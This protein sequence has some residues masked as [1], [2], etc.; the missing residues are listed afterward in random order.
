MCTL[1]LVLS[2][3]TFLIVVNHLFVA[4]RKAEIIRV[5]EC[6]LDAINSGDFETYTY[7]SHSETKDLSFNII[8]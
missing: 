2:V 1:I 4:A 7:V 8:L 3:N 6:I 5:T